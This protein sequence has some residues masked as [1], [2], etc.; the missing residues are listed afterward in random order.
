MSSKFARKQ[1]FRLKKIEKLIYVRNVNSS[2]NKEG[3][4]VEVNIYY[5]EYRKRIEID[6][7]RRQKQS[8]ILEML[9]LA[10]HNPKIDWRIGEVRITRCLEKCEKQQRLKQK[11]LEQQRQKKEEKR[12]EEEEKK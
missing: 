11:K 4:I 6:V 10:Y 8:M 5:Q 7:I 9:Q 2:F 3:H 12:E 1:E